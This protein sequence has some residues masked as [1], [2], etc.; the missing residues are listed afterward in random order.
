MSASRPSQQ[1]VPSSGNEDDQST[2]DYMVIFHALSHLANRPRT[3]TNQVIDY[4]DHHGVVSMED[5]LLIS[6]THPSSV[7]NADYKVNG[8]VHYLDESTRNYIFVLCQF[9]RDWWVRHNKIPENADW[10]SF[11]KTEFDNFSRLNFP[12]LPLSPTTPIGSS[13]ATNSYKT[14]TRLPTMSHV[15]IK[16]VSLVGAETNAY[17]TFDSPNYGAT[18]PVTK[19]LGSI[20]SQVVTIDKLVV[21]TS[22][23]PKLGTTDQK[24]KRADTPGYFWD[25]EAQIFAPKDLQDTPNVLTLPLGDYKNLLCST[26]S[27][28]SE[29]WGVDQ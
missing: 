28:V 11:T 22:A 1:R 9:A 23:L 25:L 29:E 10:L 19:I 13:S 2:L 16:L 3:I 26:T 18:R 4:F 12:N 6:I 27:L 5:L 21:P 7:P 24:D 15:K 8:Q 17:K 14:T 20:A